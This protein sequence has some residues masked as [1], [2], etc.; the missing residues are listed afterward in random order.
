VNASKQDK[1]AH[2]QQE[3]PTNQPQMMLGLVKHL[4]K[5]M[6]DTNTSDITEPSKFSGADHHWN[7]WNYIKVFWC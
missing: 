7:E 1:Q 5:A 6:K 2:A 4:A 3:T